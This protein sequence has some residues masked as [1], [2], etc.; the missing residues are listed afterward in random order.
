MKSAEFYEFSRNAHSL[1]RL[2]DTGPLRRLCETKLEWLDEAKLLES[3][4]H[5]GYLPAIKALVELGATLTGMPLHVAA[6]GQPAAVRL[7]LQLGAP[8]DN[9][10]IDSGSPICAAASQANLQ[11]ARILVEAGADVDRDGL[12]Y[13]CSAL[14]I[15]EDPPPNG[16]PEKYAAMA[17]YLRSV[18]ATKPWDFHRPDTFWDGTLGELT[19]LLVE[20]SLGLVAGPPL[21][22]HKTDISRFDIRRTRHG[23]R[24]GYR[25]Y[26][27]G[28]F[29]AGMTATGSPCELAVVTHSF[30]PTHRGA[31]KEERFR[32]PVDFLAAVGQR[33]LESTAPGHGDVLDRDHPLVGGLTWPGD[34]KQWVVV[35]HQ[36]VKT[37]AAEVG[38]P[39]LPAMLFL[40]PHLDKKPLRAGADAMA[41]AD[42]KASV[43][44][45]K[46]AMK[47]GKNNLVIPLCYT[48]PW[49]EKFL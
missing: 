26:F 23:Y 14:S 48:A 13:V 1:L 38:D 29:T 4:S 10:P 21:L 25:S 39:N 34:F 18:G 12:G 36:S 28:L 17:E 22:K 41:K 24:G 16:K 19:V 5:D 2:A 20:S 44:W 43:K 3:A 49:L 40:I 7:L 6:Y 37:R 42:F 35:E 27:Q 8:V 31:M 15:A 33:V 46:P 11:T 30:W 32:A 45:D 9:E 47:T